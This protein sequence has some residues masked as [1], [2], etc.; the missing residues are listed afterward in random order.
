MRTPTNTAAD[1][2][3]KNISFSWTEDPSTN[4]GDI[5]NYYQVEWF[6]RDTDTY[7]LQTN[8]G[9]LT[10]IGYDHWWTVLNPGGAKVLTFTHIPGTD[11]ITP[12]SYHGGTGVFPMKRV[13]YRIRAY[14]SYGRANIPGGILQITADVIPSGMTPLS[15]IEVRPRNITLTW[16]ELSDTNLNGRD[17]PNFYLLQ[18]FG[19]T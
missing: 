19:E 3:P 6:N 16:N 5:P 9:H 14:N 4:G 2:N 7:N 13:L 17:V 11:G 15:V 1:I 12:S 18:Y 8:S 10:D